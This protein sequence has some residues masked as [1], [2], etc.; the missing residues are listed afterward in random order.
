MDKNGTIIKIISNLY[1]VQSE[2][3]TYECRARG[4]FRNDKTTP[5][6]GDFV[7]F[8]Y[9]LKLIKEILPRKNMLDRP[10]VSNVDVALIVTSVKT[11]N[12]SLSL[13]DRQIAVITKSNIKPVICLTKC[14]LLNKEEIKDIENIFKYY[15]SIGIK[16]F[17][18][19]ETDKLMNYLK[20]KIVVLT[21]QTGAGKSSLINRLG[22]LNLKTDEISMALGR[23]KHTTRHTEIHEVKDVLFVDTPGFSSLDLNTDKNDLKNYFI[24]FNKYTCKYKDCNHDKEDGCS[25]KNA[26]ENNEI[27]KS[28][29]DNYIKFRGEL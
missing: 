3:E 12:L 23:G 18:N 1:T 27:L 22:D 15:E 11:P 20:D 2:D 14:D 7:V 16:V 19:T 9:K 24:E 25:V 10:N 5:L 6:V 8:D 13:L 4:K 29:Y 26:V 28:R 17:K 21:G